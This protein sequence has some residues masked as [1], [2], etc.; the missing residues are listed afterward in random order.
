MN[1][2][3]QISGNPDKGYLGLD[4]RKPR[5]RISVPRLA[6]AQTTDTYNLCLDQWKPRLT[7]TWAQT[8]GNQ[9]NGYLD[10]DQRKQVHR[11]ADTWAQTSGYLCPDQRIIGPD[12]Q[13]PD[14]K[15]AETQT[16]VYLGPDQENILGNL[17]KFVFYC[18][19]NTEKHKTTPRV[20]IHQA[21][22]WHK[23]CERPEKHDRDAM[24][25]FVSSIKLSPVFT[26]PICWPNQPW[27]LASL[28]SGSFTP[29]PLKDENQGSK[30]D[31]FSQLQMSN[32]YTVRHQK[33]PPLN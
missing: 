12:L 22:P 15:L 17:S 18:C 5:Q 13:I 30:M 8:S 16:S 31:S 33:Q 27:S 7:D 6:E 25:P 1:I 4:K 24:F 2:C 26:L 23:S 32:A 14:L 20:Q 3:A 21:P 29:S 28:G 9:I 11:L 19:K 10:P